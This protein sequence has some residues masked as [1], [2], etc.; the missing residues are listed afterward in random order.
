MEGFLDQYGYLALLVGTFFEGETALLIASSLIYRGVFDAPY[1]VFAGFAGSFISDWLYFIIGRLNGRFFIAKRPALQARLLPVQ[2]FFEK[3]KLQILLTY[4][5]LYGFRV[6]IPLI[7]GM[8]S[9]R[10]IQF[11]IYSL[12]SGVLWAT[13]VS[14]VG[15]SVGRFLDLKAS[16]FEDNLLFIVLGFAGFGMVLGYVIKRVTLRQMEESGN[17]A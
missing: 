12:V 1:A 9:V 15:Y 8:S 3:H 5:F 11:L 17:K 2:T 6:I 10:P 13:V 4:R 16:V 7:I 14:T